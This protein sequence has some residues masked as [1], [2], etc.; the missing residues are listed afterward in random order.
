MRAAA[1]YDVAAR[2]RVAHARLDAV[3]HID[4]RP[5]AE[6]RFILREH[7]RHNHKARAALGRL[8]EIDAVRTEREQR[9]IAAEARHDRVIDVGRLRS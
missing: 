6:Y 7:D 8:A 1:A 2:R 5:A 9:G 3:D 4:Q